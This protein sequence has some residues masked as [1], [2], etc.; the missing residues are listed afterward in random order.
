[1]GI[2]IA[3]QIAVLW[4]L[5]RAGVPYLAATALAVASAVVHNFVWHQRWTWADRRRDEAPLR[6]FASF[7]LA[8]GAVSLVTNLVA[9][10]ALV[11][12]LGLAPVAANLVAIAAAGL[13][14]FWL[15]DRVVFSPA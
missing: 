3:V 4:L 6:T 14:N 15:G 7:A 2:G 5:T 12:A 11:G 10:A 1:G 13:V 8:N 9:M